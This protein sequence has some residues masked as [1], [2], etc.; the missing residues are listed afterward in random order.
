MGKN[1]S[2]YQVG[3]RLSRINSGKRQKKL[4]NVLK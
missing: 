4:V 1:Y 2:S 3:R